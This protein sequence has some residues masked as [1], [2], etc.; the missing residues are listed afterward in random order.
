MSSEVASLIQEKVNEYS[1]LVAPVEN[2]IRELQLHQGMQRAR[3]ED[4]IHALSPALAAI[5]ETLGISVLDLL[6]SKDRE[7]FLREAVM[8]AALP[9]EVI[10]ER[11]LATAGAGGGEQLKALGIPEASAS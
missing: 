5:S 7:T 1:V 11:I 4:E 10:R 9:M 3:A 2:A 8:Q 6:L